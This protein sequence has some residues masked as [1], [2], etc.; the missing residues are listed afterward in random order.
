MSR[1]WYVFPQWPAEDFDFAALLK[2]FDPPQSTTTRTGPT[3]FQTVMQ[4]DYVFVWFGC[5][6]WLGC[7]IQL[8]GNVDDMLCCFKGGARVMTAFDVHL[9]TRWAIKKMELDG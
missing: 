5:G 7:Y 3:G 6:E 4:D 8:A 2:A 9:E 1:W